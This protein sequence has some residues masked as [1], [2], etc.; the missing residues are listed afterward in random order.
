M[1]ACWITPSSQGRGDP[2][3][4]ARDRARRWD[5]FLEP[6]HPGQVGER[7]EHCVGLVVRPSREHLE[8]EEPSHVT[9]HLSAR[10]GS[11]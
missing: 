11:R 9:A 3:D 10:L 5:P 7:L 1:A 6:H 2:I 8:E 4:Q